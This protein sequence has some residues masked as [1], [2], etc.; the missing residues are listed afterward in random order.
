[1]KIRPFPAALLIGTLVL[2]A[3]AVQL[4]GS[5]HADAQ[6]AVKP[7]AYDVAA[8]N[9]LESIKQLKA[10]Y[11]RL[12]DTKQWA[13]WREVFTDDFV[14]DTSE[15][16][17]KVVHGGDEFVA[18]VRQQIGRPS[19]TTVH[20]VQAPEITLTSATTATG[21]WALEDTVDL[22]PAIGMHGAGH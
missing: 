19:Q 15:A 11:C 3:A 6:T 18:F 16:G 4:T 7:G 21:I 14:S 5:R 22:T 9:D 8:L 12:L 13:A 10:R 20:Q 2:A 17:G 1:M